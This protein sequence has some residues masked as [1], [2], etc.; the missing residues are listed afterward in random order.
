MVASFLT[1]L[2]FSLSVSGLSCCSSEV[3]PSDS[4]SVSRALLVKLTLGVFHTSTVA[5]SV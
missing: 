1:P 3:P 2:R 5:V 4:V